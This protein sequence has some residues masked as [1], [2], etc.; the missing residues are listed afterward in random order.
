MS[1]NSDDDDDDHGGSSLN[2]PAADF[3]F[4]S[5]ASPTGDHGRSNGG[6]AN[7]DFFPSS[8]TGL[9]EDHL[10]KVTLDVLA[11]DTGPQKSYLWSLD[12]GIS[13]LQ[14]NGQGQVTPV[15]LLMQDTARSEGASRD[16][17]LNGARIWITGDGK[18]GYDAS[19]L[20]DG[21]KAQLQHLQVG[22]YLTDTFTYAVR[23]GEGRI[24][25]TTATVQIAGVNDPPVAVDDGPV[26]TALN[27]PI[28]AI[29]VLGNDTDID[30][31]A[32]S[33]TSASALHGT[34]QIN[35][36]GTLKYTPN[37]GYFGADSITY[38]I[39]D[40]HG[41][42]A[43]AHVAVTVAS[44]GG[45]GGTAG[46]VNDS[47]TT[48]E[49]TAVSI[50]VLANDSFTS[51]PAITGVS[52]PLHGTVSINNAGTPSDTTDD[53]IVYTP[54]ADFNGTD[55]FTYTVTAGGT[56]YTASVA[57]TV[58]EVNDRPVA[59]ADTLS[60][61]AEDSGVRS[62]AF[63]TLTANDSAGPANESGQALTITG[64]T[65]AVGG[66][67]SIVSGHIEFTP[68]A[69]FNGTASFD[70]TVTDNGTTNGAPDP[71]SATGHVSFTVTEVNDV[72]VAVNDA[73]S[74]VAEDSGT[75]VIQFTD[76][77]VN[78]SAGPANESG[79]TLTITGVTNAVGGA[80][81]IV[82]GHIEFTPSANF[83]GTAS[84]DYTVTDN[85]TTNGA[86]DP[87]SAV[88]HASF[89]VTEVNDPP[90]PVN[91]TLSSVAEDSG[92][93]VIQFTDLT[94]NDSAGPANESS[95]ALTITG[96]TNA[97]GG[98]VSI[99]SGHIEFTPSADFNG[100]A[101]FDYT[102]TDNGTT[103]GA[104][105][106]K[107]AVGHASFTVTEV[108]D[109]PVA[110]DDVLSSVAEDSGMR[111]IQ[112]S[113]LTANDSAGPANESSQ[114]LTVTNVTNAVG[115]S[116]SIVS[117]H[118]EFTP[119]ANFNGTA[120]FDYTVTD[121]GTTNGAP[122]PKSA[123][124]HASFTVTEVN[125]TP[126][127]TDD[128]LSS[129]A[130]DSG[131][132]VIQF[133]DLTANDS[134]GPPNESGQT[135]TVTNVTNAVGGSVSIVSGHI[136]FTPSANFNGTASFDYTVTDNGTTNG[137]SDPQ[138]AV[139]HASF[140]V[141]E[142]NDPPV[143][144]DD[145]LSSI[146]QGTGP[147]SI[148]FSA[149]T[150]NDSAG[151]PNESGQ[152][153]T[154]T[155]VGNAVGGT[156]AIVS[157]H[158]VFTPLVNFTGTASFDYT[159]SDNGTTNGVADPKTDIGSVSFAVV[160]D[161]VAPAVDLNGA[162]AGTDTTASFIE[163]TPVNIAPN[164]TVVDADSQTLSWLF[165][166]LSNRPDGNAVESL[167]L[168]PVATAAALAAGLTYSYTPS[169]GQFWVTGYASPGVYQ[170]ILDGLQYTNTSDNP[171][172]ATRV[173]F[174]QVNDGVMASSNRFDT[175]TITPVNDPPT[176]DLNGAAAGNDATASF[177]GTL[178][179]IAPSATV[180]DPDTV[181][182]SSLHA[183]L[184]AR[185]DGA[186]ETLSLNATASAAAAGV[187]GM[188]VSYSAVSGILSVTG[189]ASQAT[190]Q[191]ILDGIVYND[192]A[193]TPSAGDRIV[194]VVVNDGLIDSASH[195]VTISVTASGFLP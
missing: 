26:T 176:V 174:V 148:Q 127:P 10:T 108:N 59:A 39:S 58:T 152:A 46:A 163:Q 37:A 175:I 112:F 53:Y 40:G 142:V 23:V 153:L 62:I 77:T 79:Q 71:Q 115:G 154:I 43:S 22:Q 9:T 183:T 75:R 150:A 14:H 82:S 2:G 97:V 117:G 156:V 51:T 185:L 63:S 48:A 57:V 60:S 165:V 3:F 144:A 38:A 55:S 80:V 166:Q 12:N 101:S 125:D 67:V 110:T 123:V 132:R 95:Q 90:V 13:A 111:V 105:D 121:N 70:Y 4:S 128:V 28:A 179:A 6:A 99:V 102:V 19:T 169:T 7:P 32:L 85:G 137:A 100:T 31:D 65:N 92:L 20:S 74:S 68:A 116:V 146:T 195:H 94:A 33:V 72:P 87:K 42:T 76:L 177:T 141:T 129:V 161:T 139:G 86:P 16:T 109:P 73:L 187:P 136:E 107:S 178:V 15:D 181:N 44:A 114:T 49:D 66:T 30:G 35:A 194:D 180:T 5:V 93:R 118:I 188:T 88:A 173:A 159:V 171:S 134:A 124:A 64:V 131:M 189:S 190:Y 83:N 27:T 41:G 133:S 192:T 138:S 126:V 29:N 191:T 186:V 11:N 78:D 158:I 182:M 18:V 151:P 69:N 52:A 36:N 119:S 135:L 143:A 149:L 81:S 103:N 130:E 164:A 24:S 168:D 84:F 140:T 98:A 155:N 34:V 56:P 104:P 172:T 160:P 193:A 167:Q 147:R 122:D 25:W 91:D 157:G 120:S 21:F 50:H 106:P 47:A 45:G 162:A 61:V 89:T 113:D 145:V 17:S 1:R 54:N 96:V 8:V 184:S 170:T